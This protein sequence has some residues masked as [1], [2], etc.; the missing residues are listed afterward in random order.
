MQQQ[1][2]KIKIILNVKSKIKTSTAP[3]LSEGP[4]G[5]EH[6]PFFK[7]IFDPHSSLVLHIS[8]IALPQYIYVCA[9][10]KRK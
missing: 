1:Q 6:S 8:P 3:S 2:R 10:E 4:I 5:D 9:P 7:Q